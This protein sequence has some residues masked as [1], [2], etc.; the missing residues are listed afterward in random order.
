MN[1]NAMLEHINS[2]L[3]FETLKEYALIFY[4]GF[5]YYGIV[6]FRFVQG[7]I[8]AHLEAKKQQAEPR[9]F[10]PLPVTSF[11]VSSHST[12][13]KPQASSGKNG[14]ALI[15][16]QFGTSKYIWDGQY[17]SHFSGTKILEFDGV[18][19]SKFSG[20]K[21]Y[22]WQNNVFYKF[23]GTGL[24]SVSSNSISKFSGTKLFSFNDSS[25]SKFSGTKIYTFKGDIP[26]PV[27][28]MIMLVNN[29][30]GL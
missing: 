30:A 18:Y 1:L 26:V 25:I 20:T 13:H 5:G 14:Q 7:K 2:L 11:T 4:I 23:S 27:P 21:L 10:Y 8:G 28:I 17:L 16:K 22:K 24:Y 3:N 15:S 9:V 29:L 6:L 19:I 12:S